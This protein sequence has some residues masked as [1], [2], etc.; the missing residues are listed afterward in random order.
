MSINKNVVNLIKIFFKL[1]VTITLILWLSSRFPLSEIYLTLLK[2]DG[3]YYILAV[4]VNVITILIQGHKWHYINRM[5][6][7]Q[8]DYRKTHYNNWV[9]NFY[10]FFT[11]GKLGGDAYRFVSIRKNS[12][13][14][15][16]AFSST[17]IEKL[18]TL[19]IVFVIGAFS[20]LLINDSSFNRNLI[21]FLLVVSIV[22]VC[23]L[24]ILRKLIGRTL[25]TIEYKINNIKMKKIIEVTSNIFLND[26]I[27]RVCINIFGYSVLFQIVSAV[28]VYLC[29]K[30]LS[31][32]LNFLEILL[33]FSIST[34]VTALPISISGIGVRESIYVLVLKNFGIASTDAFTL[35]LLV[36]SSGLI[37]V[38]IGG[39]MEIRD[40]LFKHV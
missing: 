30:S 3:R 40:K 32:E 6:G 29:S 19:Y 14:N 16:S 36:F 12:N 28:I 27:G 22:M 24:M 26:N 5:L 23:L 8:M 11:P 20:M 39:L 33:V 9:S 17:V 2:T 7:I 10:G 38:L 1:L 25:K 13:T 15:L 37:T 18:S 31:I 35:S 4:F 21:V 34:L